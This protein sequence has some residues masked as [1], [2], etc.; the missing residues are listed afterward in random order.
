MD[1]I[2]LCAGLG[3]R[4][5]PLTNTT[6]KCLINIGETSILEHTLNSL[7]LIKNKQ[8]ISKIILVVNYKRE[9]IYKK[10]GRFHKNLPIE[11]VL[12]EKL[13][14]TFSA[15]NICK[16]HI[17]SKWFCV[18]NGDDIY[19]YKDLEKLLTTKNISV[20][21]KPIKTKEE[22]LKFGV[23]EVMNKHISKVYEKQ[24]IE[25][26]NP[27]RHFINVGAY[28]FSKDFFFSKTT[29]KT[30]RG[31][32]ELPQILL[33]EYVNPIPITFWQ[34]INTKEQLQLAQET[35]TSKEGILQKTKK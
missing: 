30:H 32:Y 12:Q 10:I 27:Q 11:Y 28:T 33:G 13:D 26:L 29:Q 22:S 20:L 21:V 35:F 15:L 14:G 16:P 34:P 23:F 9:E 3:T 8:I 1:V 2:I 6:P 31:E 24:I 19:Y 5:R 25:N 4:L 7:A 17:S 18:L